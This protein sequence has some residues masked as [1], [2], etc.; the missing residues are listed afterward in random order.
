M[1][2]LSNPHNPTGVAHAGA[3]LVAVAAAAARVIADRIHAPLVYAD[4][5]FTPDLRVDGRG[6]ALMSGSKGWNLAGP[7]AAL[8]FAGP[9]AVADLGR[10]PQALS[11][12][13]CHLGVIAHAAAFRDGEPW[14]KT[15]LAGL[16]A[17]RELIAALLAEAP[18]GGRVPA[19]AANVSRLAGLP[20]RRHRSGSVV[21]QRAR[22]AVNPGDAF[23]PGGTGYVRLN[24]AASPSIL[25]EA[26]RRMGHAVNG[27]AELDAA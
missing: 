17:N 12:G 19:A 26:I 6:F 21:L 9:D 13:P 11:H 23:G 8:L 16:T 22:V 1:L 20:R 7:K 2:L 4:A 10:F 5:Q 14:L 25:R 18:P 27:R 3:A 24:F 15:R